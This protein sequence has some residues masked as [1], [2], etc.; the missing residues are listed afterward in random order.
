VGAA[1][2]SPGGT[3]AGRDN[4]VI[5]IAPFFSIVIPT[6]NSG[7]TLGRCLDSILG[8]RF[9]NFEIIVVDGLSSDQTIEV[10][11]KDND[12]RVR[13]F[14]EKDH[15]VYDAMNKGIDLARGDW[16]LFLGSD[17][18]LFDNLV[19]KDAHDRLIKTRAELVYGDIQMFGD[20]TLAG[21]YGIYD[22]QFSLGKLFSKNIC[23]QSI[24]YSKKI[25]PK[26]G[27]Y[28]TTYSVCADW[29]LNLR[30]FARGKVQYYNRIIAAFSGGGIS[31]LT[32]NNFTPKERLR[33][34]KEYFGYS[35]LS[36]HFE[37]FERFFL[38]EAFALYMLR[39]PLQSFC[40][41]AL[42]FYHTKNKIQALKRLAVK[43]FLEVYDGRQ[44]R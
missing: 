19:L 8:Q 44:Q 6:Y 17:D 3:G 24:F 41:W 20:A 1:E 15:G 18:Q 27:Y 25:F 23:H 29:D 36:R 7:K 31:S 9:L 38:S 28:D 2:Y 11:K 43:L 30:C 14:T 32:E 26:V 39:K 40:Y 35:L 13:V 5:P 37:S 42:F 16:L 34:I 10:A 33:K 12:P 4:L 21:D 22:G